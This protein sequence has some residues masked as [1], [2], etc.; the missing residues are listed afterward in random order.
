[1]RNVKRKSRL[2]GEMLRVAEKLGKTEQREGAAPDRLRLVRVH[3]QAWINSP[4]I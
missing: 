4:A 2:E 3:R 1:M